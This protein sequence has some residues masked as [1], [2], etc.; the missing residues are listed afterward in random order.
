MDKIL[1]FYAIETLNKQYYVQGL[2]E[3]EVFWTTRILDAR[4]YKTRDAAWCDKQ[5]LQEQ[6]PAR[7]LFISYV[8]ICA[9]IN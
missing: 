4:R 7:S 5:N 8:E 2:K 3:N 9:R 6:F 1:D